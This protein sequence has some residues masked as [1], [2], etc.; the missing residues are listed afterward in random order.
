MAA[1]PANTSLASQ[2]SPR[3]D[4]FKLQSRFHF[5]TCL[6]FGFAQ[7]SFGHSQEMTP[8]TVSNGVRDRTPPTRLAAAPFHVVR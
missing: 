2:P 5:L 6:T 1:W 7:G 4:N 8:L 3:C